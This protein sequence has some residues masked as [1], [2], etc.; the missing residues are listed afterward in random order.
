MQTTP[1]K[2]QLPD[3][4]LIGLSRD[5]V[6]VLN[7]EIKLLGKSKTKLAEDVARLELKKDGLLVKIE[8]L[9]NQDKELGEVI[10]ERESLAESLRTEI[11]T[12]ESEINAGRK[13]VDSLIEDKLKEAEKC[14]EIT[15]RAQQVQ[16]DLEAKINAHSAELAAWEA[17]KARVA[18]L[19]TSI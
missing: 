12:V 15:E 3:A 11:L 18:E 4:E 16:I 19:L 9:E 7:E 14:A 8:G 2:T 17:R 5:K 13:E 10:A 1:N 6:N